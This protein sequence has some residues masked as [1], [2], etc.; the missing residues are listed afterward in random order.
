[1]EKK[2]MDPERALRLEQLYHSALERDQSERSA[3]LQG[4]C[5]RD[6][7]LRHEVE[8][9]LAHDLKADTFMEQPALEVAAR[10]VAQEKIAARAQRDVVSAG[11]AVSHYRVIEKLGGGGMGVVYRARDVRLGRSVALKFLPCEFAEDS[12]AIERFRREARAASSLNHPNICTIYDIGESEGRAFIA[13]EYL[14]GQTL[15][16]LLDSGLKMDTSRLLALAEQLAAALDAAHSQGIIHRD[17]KPANIFVTRRGDAK[18]LDFGLAKLAGAPVQ[19][20]GLAISTL[21]AEPLEDKLTSPGIAIGTVAYM[22]PEQARGENLD[23]RT[24]LFSFGAV[25]YEMASGHQAFDGRTIATVFDA[26]LNRDPAPVLNLNPDAPSKLVSIIDKA[27]AKARDLRYQ[28]AAEML[29]D[30]RAVTAD[31]DLSPGQVKRASANSPASRTRRGI[32]IAAITVALMGVLLLSYSVIRHRRADP[33]NAAKASRRSVAVMSLRNLSGRPEDAWLSTALTEMLSTELA[34]GQKLRLV[35]GEDVAR[36]KLDLRL[37]DAESFSKD[38][39][40]RVHRRLSTDV[41]ILGSYASSGDNSSRSIRL[42]LRAQ[43]AAVGETIAEVA[44]TGPRDD[45]SGTASRAGMQLREKLGVDAV[46]AADAVSVKASMPAN[47]EAA[48]LYAEGLARLRVFDA[49]AARD[50]LQR[51]IVADPDFPLARTALA[52]AWSTLGYDQKA[53]EE[54]TR[55]FELS[56]KL[57]REDRLLVEGEYRLVN[58]DFEKAIDVYR[59]LFTLF[60]DSLDYG[61]R[62]ARAQSEG[63]K[64]KDVLSTVGALRKLSMQ[65]SDD[66]RIDL[67]EGTAWADSSKFQEA[68]KP[69]ARAL[70]EARAQGARLLAANVLDEQCLN[71]RYIGQ[72]ENAIAACREARDIFAAAGDHA[73]EAATLRYWADLLWDSDISAAIDL[74][75][76]ALDMSRRIG[77]EP[78]VAGALNALG[79]LVLDQGDTVAA[80]KMHREAAAIYRRLGNTASLGAVLGNLGNDLLEGGD[81]AGAMKIYEEAAE[82]DRAAGDAGTAAVVGYSEANIHELRGEL[83]AAR[84]GF[85]ES[86][87]V[88]RQSGDQRAAAYGLYSIGEVL[89]CEA[90][91]V[92]ARKA[93]EEALAIR[94]KGDDKGKVAETE[95]FLAELSLEEGRNADETEAVARQMIEEFKNEKATEEE[96]LGWNVLTRALLAQRKF[97]EAKRDSREA[98]LLAQTTRN[99][100]LRLQNGILAARVQGLSSTPASIAARTAASKQLASLVSQ[101]KKSD[102]V[103]EEFDARLAIAEI[104][105]KAGATASARSHLTALEKE[106]RTKGFGLVAQKAAALRSSS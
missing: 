7:A 22:S 29:S 13:M 80:E 72:H 92:G 45:L 43:D 26:I 23:L 59:T 18:I 55:A 77:H 94:Q 27:L 38:T 105:L 58:R 47:T 93:G 33:P 73:G 6:D 4:A 36:A 12:N 83:P 104:E 89:L 24:D 39:L 87:K 98:L 97:E 34:A 1:V 100:E 106:A 14:D 8:S 28:S 70:E 9:L 37:P 41:V 103:G 17:I 86:L 30:L 79:L 15:K 56:S 84:Q 49:L 60:P 54:A 99:L 76:Q 63:S 62:L 48:R 69:L 42:D 85:E 11:Q 101:A 50:L 25:L 61:L 88:W 102:Y 19:G 46:S 20:T 40:A 95:L 52:T 5:G 68:Q 57:S 64:P 66:A 32:P 35:S 74:D 31:P 67:L 21:P 10:M 3:F 53:S 2:V 51:A 82:L 91:F 96:V 81:S 75:R 71:F 65:T 44:V 16:H 78:G 90:D